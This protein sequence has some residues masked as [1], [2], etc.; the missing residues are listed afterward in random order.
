MHIYFLVAAC[1][2]V[3]VCSNNMFTELY[4]KFDEIERQLLEEQEKKQSSHNRERLDELPTLCSMIEIAEA[5]AA[6]TPVVSS[7]NKQANNGEKV[8]DGFYRMEQCRY[9]SLSL[10]FSLKLHSE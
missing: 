10:S 6:S 9:F 7:Y 5:A 3:C 1:L 8:I 2:C 4:D